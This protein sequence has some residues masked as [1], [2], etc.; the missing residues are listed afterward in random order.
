MSGCE[1][2]ILLRSREQ[3]VCVYGDGV[4]PSIGEEV[5]NES[6]FF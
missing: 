5:R 6:Y 4:T 3:E 1:E 2:V